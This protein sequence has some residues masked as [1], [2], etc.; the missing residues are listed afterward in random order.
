[1]IA[2]IITII[3]ASMIPIINIII[4]IICVSLKASPSHVF[5]CHLLQIQCLGRQ[6]AST[7]A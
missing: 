7:G 6:A 1:M 4:I 5:S 2:A 3:I